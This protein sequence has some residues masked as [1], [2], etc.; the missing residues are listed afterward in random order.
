MAGRLTLALG[1]NGHDLVFSDQNLILIDGAEA[2]AQHIK[3]R[4]LLWRGEWFLNNELGVPWDTEILRKSPRGTVVEAELK[5]AIRETPN[6]TSLDA[7][8]LDYTPGT[9]S[10]AVSFRAT[11][12]FGAVDVDRLALND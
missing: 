8:S 3:T 12:P 7:F 6:V 4:L 11:T 1:L 2:V 5:A 9:R 10:L